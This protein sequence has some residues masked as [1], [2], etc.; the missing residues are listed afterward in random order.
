MTTNEYT[1]IKY[2]IKTEAARGDKA[3]ACRIVG[4]SR[5]VLDTALRAEPDEKGQVN[6]TFKEYEVLMCLIETF[7]ERKTRTKRV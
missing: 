7:N 1:K 5:T 4:V 3:N 2:R 6:L